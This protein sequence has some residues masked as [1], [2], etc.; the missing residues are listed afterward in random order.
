MSQK[1]F[2]PGHGLRHETKSI[3]IK[4]RKYNL[5]FPSSITVDEKYKLFED[6]MFHIAIENSKNVNYISEKIIDCFMSYTIPIY[7]GDSN[8]ETVFN[9]MSFI[10]INKLGTDTGI[11]MIKYLDNNLDAYYNMLGRS[12]ITNNQYDMY[13]HEDY[14]KQYINNI[15][16]KLV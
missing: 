6:T 10:N 12:L 1:N 16:N 9:E 13:Y 8:I 15:F 4:E 5:F 2:L 7:W 3:I 14:Y 11:E